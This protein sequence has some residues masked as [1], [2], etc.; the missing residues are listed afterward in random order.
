MSKYIIN[1]PSGAGGD[2][3]TILVYLHKCPGSIV[4]SSN[5]MTNIWQL[6]CKYVSPF[7]AV[8]Y[9]GVDTNKHITI[10]DQ[11]SD[12]C[13]MQT[14]LI[15]ENVYSNQNIKIVNIYSDS[16]FIKSYVNKIYECKTIRSKLDEDL[17]CLVHWQAKL[18][19]DNILNIKY[20][21]TLDNPRQVITDLFEFYNLTNYDLD[22]L[23]SL[24]TSYNEKNE[25]LIQNMTLS[26]RIYRDQTAKPNHKFIIH[27]CSLEDMKEFFERPFNYK[28]NDLINEMINWHNTPNARPLK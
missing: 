21:D 11:M 8:K 22:L 7:R 18:P 1:W 4:A 14:H 27:M 13:T 3:L 10:L 19:G 17:D 12:N 6:E 16:I 5:I 23:E 20:E 26:N 24:F 28:S 15:N 25:K 2:F 9:W